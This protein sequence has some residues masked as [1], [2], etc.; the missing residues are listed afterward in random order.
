MDESADDVTNVLMLHVLVLLI[1]TATGNSDNS[2]SSIIVMVLFNYF[3]NIFLHLKRISR[4][5]R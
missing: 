1:C 4:K 5:C 3:K 2:V